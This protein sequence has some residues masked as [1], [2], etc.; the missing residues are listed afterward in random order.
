MPSAPQP[1]ESP[2]AHRTPA[3]QIA[4]RILAAPHDLDSLEAGE[5]LGAYCRYRAGET[6]TMLRRVLQAPG[7]LVTAALSGQALVGYAALF[8]PGPDERWGQRQIPGLL[9]LGALEVDRRFRRQGL[10]R[11]LLQ[12]TFAGGDLDQAIVIAPQD[13]ADWDVEASGL[14]PREYQHAILRLFRRHG[15]ADFV[16]D[17]PLMA[18]D[19]RNFLLVRVGQK[20][21]ASLYQAFRALLTL[22]PPR[23][24]AVEVNRHQ[25]YLGSALTS[26]RQVNHLSTKEREA[27][28]RRL[29][30]ARVFELLGLEPT[31]GSDARGNRLVSFL[32]PEDQGFVRIEVRRNPSDLD[33][34]FLLKLTQ[35]TEE[36][37]E[38]AFIIVND[39]DAERFDVD[40]DPAG[41]PG[42]ILSGVRNPA[43]EVRAMRAGLA[44]GQVRR[45][46]RLFRQ[47]LPLVEAFAG[48]LGKEQLSIEGL[49][50]HHAILYEHHGFGY[51]TG[52]DHMEEIH[53]GFLPG[54]ALHA[55]LDGSTPFRMPEAA[56][57]VRGRSWA[58][59]DGILGE[60]WKVP[61]LYKIVGKAMAMPTFSNF[62]Y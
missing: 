56:G 19:P 43:E 12:T 13:A 36:F 45:G 37:L 3:D 46:L 32:C 26:I 9:E 16:T 44:P 31:T 35:P 24:S 14:S 30:P 22:G 25:R 15:F 54:G 7:G 39:P 21:P 2:A 1:A 61:R 33:C 41:S 55:R 20:A 49:F 62:I 38:I 47:A 5:G 17:D 11:R 57:T 59:H 42:G 51:L 53:R 4:L 50:Y 18:A 6:R 34:V 27:T 23:V 48:E 40:R 28:Y 29:I 52:R 10:A 60:P 58:I 8:R